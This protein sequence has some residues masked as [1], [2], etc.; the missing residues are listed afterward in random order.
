M[1]QVLLLARSERRNDEIAEILHINSDTVLR[2][3]NRFI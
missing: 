2:V 3:N 1:A